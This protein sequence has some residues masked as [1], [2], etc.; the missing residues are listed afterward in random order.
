M[1]PKTIS[2][3]Q[4]LQGTTLR[5]TQCEVYEMICQYK[6]QKGSERSNIRDHQ[7]DPFLRYLCR[8]TDHENYHGVGLT[9]TPPVYDWIRIAAWHRTPAD[10][11]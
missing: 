5:H 1:W 9:L 11:L 8:L 7:T 3:T 2:H 4:R 6:G 10:H